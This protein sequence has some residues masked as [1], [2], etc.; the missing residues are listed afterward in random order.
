MT[1]YQEIKTLCESVIQNEW[2]P[3]QFTIDIVEGIQIDCDEGLTQPHV[4]TKVGRVA[5]GK[6]CHKLSTVFEAATF[7]NPKEQAFIALLNDQMQEWNLILD[8]YFFSDG[9]KRPLEPTA[10]RQML[11]KTA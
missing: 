8:L 4:V 1:K 7:K 5:V 2:T 6:Y 11:S 10:V 9:T 3:S